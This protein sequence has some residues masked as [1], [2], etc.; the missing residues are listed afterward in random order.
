MLVTPELTESISIL[1][2]FFHRGPGHF[3][4]FGEFNSLNPYNQNM[5][6]A[7]VLTVSDSCFS[8]VRKDASGPAVV[9]LLASRGFEVVSHDVVQDEQP[10]I[11][12]WLRNACGKAPL[13]VTTGGTGL[14][15]RDV[16]PEATR[17][18]C[19][20]LVEGLAE[21]MRAEGLKQTRYAPLSRGV[22]GTL[23]TS[24][25]LN[26][27]GSPQ[28][29]LDSLEAVLPI[30]PHALALLSGAPVQHDTADINAPRGERKGI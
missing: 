5:I 13:V 9:G 7:A 19:E 6:R 27:P 29:A 4:A 26:L 25:I 14:A 10:A 17:A 8:G 22:C 30:L 2:F 11:E 23:G 21:L 24:L 28:G 20:R 1:S 16:T 12:A 18:V 3:L 15:A